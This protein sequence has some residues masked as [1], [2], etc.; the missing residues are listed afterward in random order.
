MIVENSSRWNQEDFEELINTAIGLVA[1][2]DPF[3][4]DGDGAI[5]CVLSH[6]TGKEMTI[7]TE[8]IPEEPGVVLVKIPRPARFGKGVID[9][10]ADLADG[11]ADDLPHEWMPRLGAAVIALVLGHDKDTRYGM[12]CDPPY[13]G[14]WAANMRLRSLPKRACHTSFRKARQVLVTM[15][16]MHDVRK[17][18]DRRMSEL[19]AEL[20]GK[21][22]ALQKAQKKESA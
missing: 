6:W 17:E 5:I 2:K 9:Q 21:Q 7:K 22:D 19:N 3:K 13:N 10:L 14:T 8:R 4:L 15:K 18:F 20:V 11:N 12:D 1:H 16:E